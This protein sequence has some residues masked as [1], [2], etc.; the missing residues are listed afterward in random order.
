[1]EAADVQDQERLIAERREAVIAAARLLA[2]AH[3]LGDEQGRMNAQGRLA[4]AIT[5]LE[6]AEARL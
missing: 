1:M 2:V 5:Q 4:C 6:S 3:K